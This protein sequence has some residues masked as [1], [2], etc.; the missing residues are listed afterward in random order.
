MTAPREPHRPPSP[1]DRRPSPRGGHPSSQS[2]SAAARPAGFA[3]LA[4]ARRGL[5]HSV[6]TLAAGALL[7][8]VGALAL[9]ATAQAQ[10]T[11]VSNLGQTDYSG[12]S[13]VSPSSPRAQQFETGSNPGGYTLTEIVVNIRDAR[14]GT[15]A[16]ALYTST[17]SNFPGTKVVDLNGNSSTAGEQS[18]SPASTTTLSASTKYLIVFDMTNGVA[19]LQGT[20]SDNIDSGASTGWDIAENSVFST[21][22]GTSWGSSSRSVEIAI[23]GT[24]LPYVTA[25]EVSTDGLNIALTFSRNLDHPSYTSTIRGA[26]TVTVGGTDNP[27]TNTTGATDTVTVSV[28]RAIIRG[29]RVVLSYDQSAAGTEALGDSGGSK[30]ADFTTGSGGIPAVVN[31]STETTAPGKPTGLMANAVGDT[32]INLVW[33]APGFT[34]GSAITGYK[35]EVS[36]DG[37]T[38]WTD[39]VANTNSTDT[40]Y[41]H[42]GLAA[43]STRHYRV[44]AINAAGTS[45]ASGTADATT[46]DQP[47]PTCTLNTADGDIWCGVVTVAL[48]SISGFDVAYGFVDA[49][50][51]TGA[52]S[53]TG[54]RVGTNDYTIDRAAVGIGG[55]AETLYFGLTSALTDDDKEKLVLHI[56]GSSDSFAFSAA[57]GPD[58]A[59]NY[60][61]LNTGLD[62]S[63]EEYVTLRLREVADTTA[64]VTIAADKAI[65]WDF[66]GTAGFTLS[67][68]G[69]TTAVLAVTV[70]V[71]QQE[72]RDLLPDGAEAER[73]V[74]FA[75]NSATTALSVALE[76]DD[77]AELQG[78]LTVEVQAGLGLHGGRPGFGH[79]DGARWRRRTAA[80]GEPAGVGG[81]GGRRGGAVLGRARAAPG[82]QPSPVPVQDGRE[83]RRVDGYSEQWATHRWGWFEPDRL[84]GNRL[85]GRAVAHLPGADAPFET[86]WHHARRQ[87]LL[88]RGDGDAALGGGHRHHRANAHKCERWPFRRF[89]DPSVQRGFAPDGWG[90]SLCNGSRRLLAHRQRRRAKYR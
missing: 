87:R 42:T 88:E 23:T 54:V 58:S 70:A 60:Q 14:T 13:T 21:D 37:G 12:S 1:P 72:D 77:L 56:D 5:V 24:D 31:N 86:R 28:S 27:V 25:V 53:D 48:Y 84:H 63:S 11:F 52:L 4:G 55:Q 17:T 73:T 83:L 47:A 65:V 18:F 38:T 43:G 6:R 3:R 45:G 44:S 7:A 40:N 69:P 82:V 36:S 16:F 30:V 34:G 62:W 22:S 15:P 59:H 90:G 68:T 19:N 74:T 79:G 50:V 10:T 8:L 76:N 32:Q 35:I 2:A 20:S 29:Q 81:G 33:V 49:A 80:A 26:F 71:T 85:G 39:L 57:S 89:H 51:D 66:D 67:R 9:P 46:A 41:S 64:V 78:D 61:W 75:V